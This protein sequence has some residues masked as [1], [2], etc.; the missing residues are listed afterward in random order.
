MMGERLSASM[1][2]A[3]PTKSYFLFMNG[4]LR[5]R[6]FVLRYLTLPRPGFLRVRHVIDKPNSKTGRYHAPSYLAR[7][8]YVQ[9]GFFNRWGLE[10][11]FVRAFGADVPGSK[12]DLYIPQ[13]YLFEELGPKAVHSM[14]KVEMDAWEEKLGM[15]RPAGCPFAVAG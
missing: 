11:W 3:T 12:G 10:G 15:E 9:P 13:G 1:I 6:R 2:Y 8:Y 14:G 5:T 7:P 4:I